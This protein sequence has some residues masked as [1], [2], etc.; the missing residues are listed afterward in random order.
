MVAT[1]AEAFLGNAKPA[2]AETAYTEAYRL[3]PAP[4][5]IESTKEQRAQLERLLAD[6][7]LRYVKT[8]AEPAAAGL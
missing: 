8:E 7:P 5:M 4:W 6:S 1:K 2:E 3:A